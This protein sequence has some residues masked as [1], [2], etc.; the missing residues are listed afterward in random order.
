MEPLTPLNILD[1][2]AQ[3]C[4]FLCEVSAELRS[5]PIQQSRPKLFKDEYSVIPLPPGTQSSLT[6]FT[7]PQEGNTL[8]ISL[9]V[10]VPKISD[11]SELDSTSAS[12]QE[13]EEDDTQE[14]NQAC[15]ETHSKPAP[16]PVVVQKVVN[17]GQPLPQK[18]V[19]LTNSTPLRLHNGV[20]S[21]GIESIRIAD[22]SSLIPLTLDRARYLA[23]LYSLSCRNL[24]PLPNLWILCKSEKQNI[25][26]LGCSFEATQSLLYTYTITSEGALSDPQSDKA[27]VA[28]KATGIVKRVNS[29][30]M[31]G[32]VFSLYKITGAATA[33]DDKMAGDLTVQFCWTNP[34]KPLCP[35]PDTSDAVVR[36]SVTPGYMFSPVLVTYNEL[37]TLL[38]F[39][40]IACGQANWP[41]QDETSEAT[42]SS[43]NISQMTDS[44]LE[45]VASP[46]SQP[47]DATVISP[48]ADNTIYETRNDLDFAE[49]LWMFAKDAVSLDDLQQ[50][51]AAVFKALLLGKVQPF[52]HRNST[53]ALALLLRQLLHC[54]SAEDRQALAPRFQSLLSQTK[55]LSCLIQIGLEKM[56]RDYRAFFVGSEITTDDQLDQFYST[57]GSQSQLVQCHTLCKLHCVLEINASVL[58]FLN[59]PTSTLSSLTKVVLAVF[60]DLQFNTFGQTPVIALPLPAYSPSLKSVA[61]LCTSLHPMIWS[62]S[63][64]KERLVTMYRNDRLFVGDREQ[65]HNVASDMYYVYR[66]Q[67]DCACMQ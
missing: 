17:T 54:N 51:F 9:Y 48:T 63:P 34:E 32:S 39:C 50:I 7:G 59:F 52:V 26:S 29:T 28:T 4:D 22:I 64:S 67:F 24:K 33:T 6:E 2:S 27:R 15:E 56:K 13:L 8:V 46:L 53:S 65:E 44:F 58:S 38:K 14:L 42:C 25:V 18:R 21:D 31:I 55:V 36:V 20:T 11:Q 19:Y 12:I 35:P 40:Q 45:E 66:A 62:F 47:L 30:Q 43:G 10:A 61:S 57:T 5:T 16:F 3:F 41:T 37:N 1:E 23:S 60:R 49:R